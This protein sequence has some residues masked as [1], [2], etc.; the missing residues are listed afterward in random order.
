MNECNTKMDELGT[1]LRELLVSLISE[2]VTR[3][4]K[5]E[6]RQ[7]KD[8]IDSGDI[9]AIEEAFREIYEG[10]GIAR[11]MW[12]NYPVMKSIPDLGPIEAF[13]VESFNEASG[14]KQ[15][16]DPM[17][18]YV[19]VSAWA[20]KRVAEINVNLDKAIRMQH[21][22]AAP[23]SVMPDPDDVTRIKKAGISQEDAKHIASALQAQRSGSCSKAVFVTVDYK[24]IL[25]HR[26]A[27]K[28]DPGVGITCTTPLYAVH[29]AE[30]RT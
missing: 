14:S 4:R 3:K 12:G 2:Q 17:Q 29:H 15:P 8:P 20:L 16:P 30:A 1:F 26:S 27:V 6:G 13:I 24:S 11:E 5:Q 10:V 22:F 23:R 9:L 18:W 28:N 19:Q 25:K 7:G 21:E